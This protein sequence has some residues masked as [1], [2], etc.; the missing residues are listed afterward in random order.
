MFFKAYSQSFFVIGPFL[1]P[2]QRTVFPERV[3]CLQVLFEKLSSKIAVFFT[4][5]GGKVASFVIKYLLFVILI[6]YQGR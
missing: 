5:I 6:V 3:V 2:W 1:E 4:F